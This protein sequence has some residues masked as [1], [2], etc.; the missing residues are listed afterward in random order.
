[1]QQRRGI[2]N[3]ISRRSIAH[4]AR[5]CLYERR[6]GTKGRALRFSRLKKTKTD[7]VDPRPRV[8]RRHYRIRNLTPPFGARTLELF[9]CQRN[10][11]PPAKRAAGVLKPHEAG[12]QDC[13]MQPSLHVSSIKPEISRAWPRRIQNR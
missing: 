9:G 13:E 5:Y 12:A 3:R 4:G 6:R 1:M 8:V 10:S 7:S 11:F 2:L